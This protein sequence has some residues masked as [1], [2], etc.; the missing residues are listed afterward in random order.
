M[1][2][3]TK[4]FIEGMAYTLLP[5]KQYCKAKDRYHTGRELNTGDPV[6]YTEKIWYLVSYNREHNAELLRMCHDKYRVR[7]Y[8]ENKL[9]DDRI[10]KKIYGLYNNADEINFDELPGSFAFKM[11]QSSGYNIFVKD[12]ADLDI[13]ETKKKLNSWLRLANSWIMRQNPEGFFFDGS[14]KILCEEY[15]QDG[16]GRIPREIE[17]FCFNGT[18]RL[19]GYVTDAVEVDESGNEQKVIHRNTYDLD[20]NLIPVDFGRAR[21][22]SLRVERPPKLDLMLEIAEKLSQD[23][24]FVRV[25]LYNLNGRILLGELTWTP[26][27]GCVAVSPEHYDYE[28]GRMLDI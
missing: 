17:F 24:K 18:P 16:N 22:E 4:R 3:W 1:N 2:D 28:F 26:Q 12:K 6:T 15:L 8:V 25:D 13:A 7:E 10:L 21:D 23:F 14:A 11:T 19:I 20:W 5:Y 9:G 27:G